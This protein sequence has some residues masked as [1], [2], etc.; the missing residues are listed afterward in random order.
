MS[1]EV[2]S[3]VAGFCVIGLVVFGLIGLVEMSDQVDRII[4]NKRIK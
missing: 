2:A 3:S 1:F 4:R